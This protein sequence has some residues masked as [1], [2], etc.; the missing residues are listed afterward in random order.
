MKVAVNNFRVDPR[1]DV[2]PH[3]E[4]Q[5]RGQTAPPRSRELS[6]FFAKSGERAFAQSLQVR[7]EVQ[8]SVNRV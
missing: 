6:S 8:G 3:R 2:S 1:K 4:C 5:D 7:E